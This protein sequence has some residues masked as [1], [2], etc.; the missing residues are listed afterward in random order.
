MNIDPSK[1]SNFQLSMAKK[2]LLVSKINHNLTANFQIKDLITL[3][4]ANTK[5]RALR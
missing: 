5:L 1:F 2:N 3:G 4:E